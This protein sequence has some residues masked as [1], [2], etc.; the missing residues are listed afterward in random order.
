MEATQV[1]R[2]D[3]A[4]SPAAAYLASRGLEG[5]VIDRFKL[6][7]VDEPL[8]G[9]EM[10]RGCMAIPYLRWSQWRGWSVASIRF[11][12]ISGQGAKYL[13]VAGDSPRL[14][15]TVALIRH[16]PKIAITEGELDAMTS[17]M[18]GLPAVGLPG[19]STWKPFMREMFLGYR[20]VFVLADGDEPGMKF[21]NK[22]GADLPNAKIIPMPDGEDVNSLVQ[23]QGADALLQRV[24]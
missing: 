5:P 1:Y 2:R 17:Q 18:V 9:H 16:T 4:D 11:R 24:S 21:A 3:M 15:N 22:V 10:F 7:Y 20:E 19:A 14:F 6:G 23:L 13:T 8:P 12:N